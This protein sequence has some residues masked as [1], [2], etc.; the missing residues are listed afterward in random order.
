MKGYPHAES[1]EIL[2]GSFQRAAPTAI[3]AEPAHDPL[4][5]RALMRHYGLPSRLLD[6][7]K[8]ACVAAY[9]AA[10]PPPDPYCDFAIW[11]IDEAA[12]QRS[13]EASLGTLSAFGA[14][15]SPLE[16]GS[17][18]L[19]S[20]AFS[21]PKRFVALVD[22]S[23]KSPRQKAQRSLFLCPGDPGYPFWRNLQGISHE[24]RTQGSMY[25]VVLP[26]GT[27]A[28]VLAD[29]KGL[30]I[31]QTHLLPALDD[32]EDLCA[33]L[34]ER[35]ER[36]QKGHGHFEWKVRVKPILAKYGLLEVEPAYYHT[37]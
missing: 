14:P 5:W 32:V 6:C 34:K 2:I 9:F 18:P 23:H 36:S 13:A 17:S 21:N 7:T 16:L 26:S 1:E 15:L 27:R 11:A 33:K 25:K 29:L 30:N 20:E 28:E 35:L 12:L 4:S 19:F 10:E 22:A 31:D 8:S 3:H 24:H 37:R